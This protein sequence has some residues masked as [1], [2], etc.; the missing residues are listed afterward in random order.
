MNRR[1]DAA[2]AVW[3]VLW[4]LLGIWTGMEVWRLSDFTVTV[5]DSGYAI[6]SAGRALVSLDPVPV[7]GDRSAEIG[8]QVRE[9]A[10]DIVADAQRARD[11]FRRLAVLLGVVVALVPSVPIVL[12]RTVVRR[13]LLRAA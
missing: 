2:V 8:L 4:L 7:V 5:E 12:L 9:N 3:V 11:S 10:A 1:V 6:D 13:M